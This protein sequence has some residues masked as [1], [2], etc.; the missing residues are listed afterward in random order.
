MIVAGENRSARRISCTITPLSTTNLTWK[1]GL[2]WNPH[3]CRK[4]PAT[5]RL[6]HGAQFTD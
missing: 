1:S 2:G 3:L 6:S 4:S 5:N